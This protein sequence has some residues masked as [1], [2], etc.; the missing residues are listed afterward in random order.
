MVDMRTT[1]LVVL[2]FGI[3]YISNTDAA[4]NKRYLLNLAMGVDPTDRAAVQARR[5][6]VKEEGKERGIV[7][8]K[9]YTKFKPGYWRKA[10]NS[11]FVVFNDKYGWSRDTTERTMKSICTDT[12]RNDK[13]R[14]KKRA[15]HRCIPI[16]H[17]RFRWLRYAQLGSA[18]AATYVHLQYMIG[19]PIA[20]DNVG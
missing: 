19:S 9:S 3:G 1:R 2:L 16:Y 15:I 10:V 13:I 6:E 11:L 4:H 12:S 7:L 8:N 14:A 20:I 5:L 17:P 18:I